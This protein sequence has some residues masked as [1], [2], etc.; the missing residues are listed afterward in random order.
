MG[1]FFCED[2][3]WDPLLAQQEDSFS[4]VRQYMVFYYSPLFF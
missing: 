3:I 1:D 2:A 4:Q